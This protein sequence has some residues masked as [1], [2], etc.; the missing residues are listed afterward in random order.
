MTREVPRES[1]VEAIKQLFRRRPPTQEE[2]AA[3]AEAEA[4][5]EQIRLEEASHKS[6]SDT[7]R[8]F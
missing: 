5:R 3:Q 2:L 1:V 6:A 8:P 7:N 4:V